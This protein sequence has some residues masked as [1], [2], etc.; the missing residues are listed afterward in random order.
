MIMNM[1]FTQYTKHLQKAFR[2]YDIIMIKYL[3]IL[4]GVSILACFWALEPVR[5]RLGGHPGMGT[6]KNTNKSL[7]GTLLLEH[8]CDIC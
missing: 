4:L 2:K 7:W 3:E 1:L 8:I 5:G 6:Q